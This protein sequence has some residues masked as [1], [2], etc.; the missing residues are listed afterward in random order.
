MAMAAE[1]IDQQQQEE[2]GGELRIP[3]LTVLKNNS[4]L[5]NIFI[6]VNI[7][8]TVLIGRHHKC[9]VV[10]AHPSVSRFHL[11]I[12]C[13][14]SSRSLSLT[15]LSSVHGT[16][17]NGTKLQA[18]VSVLMNEGDTFTVGVSSRV[19]RLSWIPFTRAFDSHIPFVFQFNANLPHNQQ[20]QLEMIKEVSFSTEEVQSVD[21]ITDSYNSLLVE[22]NEERNQH[23]KDETFEV[24]NDPM[25]TETSHFSVKVD[26]D[27]E[28]FERRNQVL[29]PPFIQSVDE[30]CSTEKT[31]ACPEAELLEETNL[32]CTLREYLTESLCL[33]V[34]EALQGTTMQQFQTPHNSANTQ[35][36]LRR[37]EASIEEHGSS[38]LTNI[39]SESID[40]KRVA[41]VTAISRESECTMGVNDSGERFF[42]SENSSL[43]VEA[44][45]VNSISDGEEQEKCCEELSNLQTRQ[46]EQGDSLD[47]IVDDTGSKSASSV[48]LK[49]APV[50][51][52]STQVPPEAALNVTSKKEKQTLQSLIAIAGCCEVEM[53]ESHAEATE[54]GNICHKKGLPLDEADEDIGNKYSSGSINP[55][56][57]IVESVTSS[58][59]Q[60]ADLLITNKK[61]DQN[62]Q[63]LIA[64]VGNSDNE[65]FESFEEAKVM[66]KSFHEQVHLPHETIQEEHVDSPAPQEVILKI[67]SDE[68]NQTLQ[69]LSAVTGSSEMEIIESGVEAMEGA[70]YSYK[71]GHPMDEA[72]EDIANDCSGTIYPISVLNESVNS[73]VTDQA[74]IKITNNMGN[75]TPKSRIPLKGFSD[76]RTLHSCVNGTERSSA[77]VNIWL[78]GGKAASS[79][80]VRA[81]RSRCMS[82]TNVYTEVEMSCEKDIM[83]KSFPKK[84]LFS[85]FDTEEKIFAQNKENFSPNMRFVRIKG[86]HPK[87]QRSSCSEVNSSPNI[88]SNE[89]ISS[90]SYKENKAPKV[91][92]ARKSRRKALECCTNWNEKQDTMKLKKKK[93]RPIQSL[94]NSAGKLKSESSGPVSDAKSVDGGSCASVSDNCTKPCHFNGE[95]K[96]S[97]DMV[98]DTA[99]LLNKESRKALQL[100]QGL[101]GTRLI[102]PRLV[103]RELESMRRQFGIF[104]RVSEA[105]FA[106]EWIKECMVNTTWWIHIESSMEERRMVAPMPSTSPQ[107]QFVE[108]EISILGP[109][110]SKKMASPTVEDHILDCALLLRKGDNNRQLVLLSDVVPLKIKSM[111]EGL[112]CETVREFQ[113]SLVNP[114]SQ[115]FMWTNSTPR[116]LTWSY[117]DDVVLREKYCGLP[118]KTGLK[119]ITE[120]YLYSQA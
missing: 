109:Y 96:R 76:K 77:F 69:P 32:L 95:Q 23:F 59:P 117:Q 92:Q 100:L 2:E 79:P 56:S 83:N 53:L 108:D 82:I 112:L 89:S 74:D 52:L 111:A 25:E 39:D 65:V 62:M 61:E 114:F 47:G 6:V 48:C 116:G 98:V 80:Q 46:N 27:N 67:T 20:Q 75:Q 51:S 24:Q 10:L 9:D 71:Q 88:N 90:I 97:W 21:L 35:F 119:L 93:E 107:P 29:L 64:A 86:N 68:E 22:Q 91:V 4:I 8:S 115:R 84:D 49:L 11:R 5:K 50:E 94:M 15:D 55:I 120:Q 12:F 54:C 44:V 28:P 41:S 13:H 70:K 73:S 103:I 31:E 63:S 110:I 60:E 18:G 45:D 26:S 17:L 42:S 33:P 118:S 43:L 14:P 85:V 3:V 38:F 66:V 40:G 34:V 57:I 87:S 113:Q 72:V 16:W 101:N 104:K 36:P 7:D 1:N 102:I 30:V 37:Q 78:R 58:V 81:R 105:S 106:L 99:S 19:Y